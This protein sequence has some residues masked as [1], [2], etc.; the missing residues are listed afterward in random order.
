M[1][2][3]ADHDDIDRCVRVAALEAEETNERRGS[4]RDSASLRR[5]ATADELAIAERDHLRVGR[6]P[7]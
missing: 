1:L 5:A 7:R 6:K 4:Q 2:S 3:N